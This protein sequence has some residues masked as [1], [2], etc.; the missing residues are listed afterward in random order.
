MKA[1]DQYI[2]HTLKN[3]SFGHFQHLILILLQE[4]KDFYLE[5]QI[6]DS[7]SDEFKVYKTLAEKVLFIDS[8]KTYITHNILKKD[9]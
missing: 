8:G 1:K 3:D 5:Y 6:I 7:T 2:R 4:K 9:R